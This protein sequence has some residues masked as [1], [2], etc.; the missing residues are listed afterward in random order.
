MIMLSLSASISYW[1]RTEPDRLAIIYADQRVTYGSLSE[2]VEALA[3]LLHRK[4]I[5][6]GE[7]VALLMKNSSAFLELSI[8]IGHA[9]AVMLPLNYRL[10]REEVDYIAGHAGA[11]L[12]FVD[13]ELE[14][15]AQDFAQRVLVDGQCQKDGR[16]LCH[17]HPAAH[18]C[19]RTRR[20]LKA[21]F[22]SCTHPGRQIVL[23]G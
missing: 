5:E 15:L 8:A 19:R 11:S 2:R 6:A 14:S 23:R 9:G 10:S 21:C 1:A 4:G 18:R 12:V 20:S 7:V 22:V 17:E 3:A 13:E 16:Y